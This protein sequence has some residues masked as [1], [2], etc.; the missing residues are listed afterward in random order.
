MADQPK[1]TRF[2][3]SVEGRAVARFGSGSPGRACELIGAVRDGNS[4]VWD[5]SKIVPLTEQYCQRYVR[6]L[7]KAVRCGDLVE[8]TKAAYEAQQKPKATTAAK[9]AAESED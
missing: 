4:I 8:T 9:A 1:F 7:N 2:F 6:E 5:T 3:Q